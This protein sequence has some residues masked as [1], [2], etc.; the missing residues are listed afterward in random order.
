M[1]GSLQANSKNAVI[2]IQSDHGFTDFD[3]V[4]SDPELFFKNYSALYFPDNDYSSIY[5]TVSNINTFPILFNKY[6]NTKIPL[7]KDTTVFLEN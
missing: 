3:G 5:D 2:I 4:P 1:N 7:Q 6:F